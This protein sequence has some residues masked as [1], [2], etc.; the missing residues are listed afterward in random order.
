MVKN[1][2]PLYKSITLASSLFIILLALVLCVT[3]YC[4]YHQAMFRQYESQMADLLHYVDSHIDHYDLEQCILGGRRSSKLDALQAFM[5]DV[6]TNHNISHLY[7][8]RS[9]E[10]QQGQDVMNVMNSFSPLDRA[11]GM[12]EEFYLGRMLTDV[13]SPEMRASFDRIQ[14][15][16]ELAFFETKT[17]YGRDYTAA[18]PLQ[19][20]QGE[21]FALL[22]LNLPIDLIQST[23]VRHVAIH[24]IL[25]AF[26]GLLFII[27]FLLWI[28]SNVTQ[29]IMKLEQSVVSFADVSHSQRNPSL[30]VYREPEIH[31]ENEVESLSNAVARMSA[32]MREYAINIINAEG[33]VR[34]MQTQVDE[35]DVLAHQDALTKVKNKTAYQ[36]DAQRIE[37]EI[38]DRVAR[39]GIVMIDLNYLKRINDSYGHERGDSYIVSSVHLIC[40]I[41]SHSPVYRVGGDEFVVLLEGADYNNR[42]ELFRLLTGKFEVLAQDETLEPWNRLSA[43]AGMAVFSK[44][45]TCMEDVFQRADEKMYRHKKEMKA[46]RI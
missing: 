24:F 22:C 18:L 35:M 12:P 30:L 19:N 25:I 8:I 13:Y 3:T 11:A 6:Y 32:D 27:F 44:G 14:K 38:L 4:S 29:P 10:T 21:T 41:Y 31:T 16:G 28:R 33:R 46:Q 20:Q 23:I 37:Q 45:D 43:A 5:D 39:F 1:R 34:Q 17:E 15:A 40:R 36:H 26:M 7:I 42:M 9:V 2:K